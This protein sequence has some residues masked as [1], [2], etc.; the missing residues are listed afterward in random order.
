[1]KKGLFLLLVL[2]FFL[3]SQEKT[4]PSLIFFLKNSSC[5]WSEEWRHLYKEQNLHLALADKC[6]LS[7]L[8]VESCCSSC[9]KSACFSSLQLGKMQFSSMKECLDFYAIETLPCLVLVDGSGQIMAR[10]HFFSI[11]FEKAQSIIEN[12]LYQ[13]RRVQIELEI[14]AKNPESLPSEFVSRLYQDSLE[15]GLKKEADRVLQWGLAH[16][17]SPFFWIQLYKNSPSTE[18]GKLKKKLL[19]RFNNADAVAFE[20]LKMDLEGECGFISPEAQ[21]FLLEQFLKQRTEMNLAYKRDI[22]ICLAKAYLQLENEEKALGY[23]KEALKTGSLEEQ[24]ALKSL[25]QQI[26]ENLRKTK[27]IVS[28]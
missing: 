19:H 2:P 18:R 10:K 24:V 1:M 26:E 11:S 14:F 6:I 22:W 21:I 15:M 27:R 25:Q 17:S 12:L 20:I 13:A 4:I 5:P 28:K 8:E 23:L 3:W 9:S 16:D 7:S